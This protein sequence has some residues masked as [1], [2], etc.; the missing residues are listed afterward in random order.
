MDRPDFWSMPIGLGDDTAQSVA[1]VEGDASMPLLPTHKLH[2]VS[3]LRC[4]L[5]SLEEPLPFLNMGFNTEEPQAV[6]QEDLPQEGEPED[7][8]GN[9]RQIGIHQYHEMLINPM[10]RA[11]AGKVS[12][13]SYT[14]ICPVSVWC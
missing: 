12:S 2:G 7:A 1:T 3:C 8:P 13:A 14:C 9:T 10:L 5:H 4:I 11:N 6:T